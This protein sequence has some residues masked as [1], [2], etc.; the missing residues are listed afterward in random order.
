MSSSGG[1]TLVSLPHSTAVRTVDQHLLGIEEADDGG[2][3]FIVVEH[4]S[5]TD[6]RF[7]G[8]AALAAAIAGSEHVTGRTAL[9]ST[10]QLVGTA[11]LGERIELIA[12]VVASGRSVDQVTVRG[13]VDGDR[14]VF[15][16][17]GGAATAME[18]GLS[19]RRPD[20]AEGAAA[21]GL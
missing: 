1:R 3:S 9:W 17:V 16:A 10:T 5:R 12:E 20:H 7:Y 21:G 11:A 6:G 19:R 15:N 18:D 2:L 14:L 13:V 8:G 4:L